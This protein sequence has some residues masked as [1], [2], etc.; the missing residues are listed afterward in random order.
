M[1]AGVH[2]AVIPATP[3]G[4]TVSIA[5]DAGGRL[6]LPAVRRP[7]RRTSLPL[8]VWRSVSS[9]GSSAAPA[10]VV[11]LGFAACASRRPSPTST[12]VWATDIVGALER[13]IAIPNV[14][15]AYDA[16]WA[17]HGP[18][19][20]RRRPGD[21]VVPAPPHRRPHR[22]GPRAARPHAGRRLRDPRQRRR[23]PRRHRHPLRPPRQAAG[24]DRL[25]RGPRP[26]D[27]GHPRTT[28]STAGAA[29]TTAT[30]PSPPSP[31]SRRCRPPAARHPRCVVLIEASEESGSPDLAAHVDALAAPPRLAQP[32][33]VP[34][35]GLPRLRPSLGHHLAAGPGRRHPHRRDPR[36]GRPLG[37]RPAASCPTPSASP[38]GSWPAIED[39]GTGDILRRGVPRRPSRRSPRRGRGHGRPARRRPAV[40][41]VP[42]RRRRRARRG[43][44]PGRPAPAPHVGAAA[45]G[46]RRRR[47]AADQPGRQR[48]AALDGAAPVDAAPADLRLRT[49]RR[50]RW[51]TA[52]TADPPYGAGVH[53]DRID[54][55]DGWNA[56]SFAPWLRDA[57]DEASQLTF[58]APAARSARAA[59]SRSWACSAPA[60]P[61]RSS[62]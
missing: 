23:R 53:F 10:L 48:A 20:R 26:V 58:G 37:H 9:A 54:S 15:P 47:P 59:R 35:L 30:P 38:A 1:G 18:H 2:T 3:D 16:D 12:T 6:T 39:A 22:R 40:G 31:P 4:D 56:P 50:R 8:E 13:F 5:V 36:R 32:R 24:D 42:L 46:G 29:P 27:A 60:S 17:G 61:R 55:A 34:R 11:V 19:G 49:T 28:A 14:S 44:R 7:G 45:G 21:R 41:R 52:L 51:P 62:W 25:A 57:L 43:R 33:A